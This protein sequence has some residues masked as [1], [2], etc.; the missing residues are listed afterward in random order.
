MKGGSQHFTH[1][2]RRFFVRGLFFVWCAGSV[3]PAAFPVH[4]ADAALGEI[5]D[6]AVQFIGIPEPVRLRLPAAEAGAALAELATDPAVEFA[7]LVVHYQAAA[8][9][10][11]DPYYADQWYLQKIAAPEAWMRTAGKTA[12]VVAVLDTGVDISHPDLSGNIW[13][14]PREVADGRDND[15]NGYVDDLHGWNFYD[16]NS[17]V[18]PVFEAYTPTGIHHGTLIAGEIGAVGGN[19][20]G[21]AGVNWRVSILPLRVL[22]SSGVGDLIN[23]VDGINYAIRA[24]ANVITLSF[25][26][27]NR[28]PILDDAIRRAHDA[29][30]LVVAAAGNDSSKNGGQDLD[31]S[32]VYPACSDGPNGENWVI[33]VAATDQDDRKATFS[34]F[35]RSCVDL[36]APGVGMVSTKVFSANHEGYSEYYGGRYNGTS[37]A[38]PLV[39]G[40]AALVKSANPAL[41]MNQIRELLFAS[42]DGIDA[43]NP[44]YAGKL[45]RG[46]LNVMRALAITPAGTGTSLPISAGGLPVMNMPVGTSGIV[47][48]QG[49]GLPP[50]VTLRTYDGTVHASF[51]AYA[52]TFRGGVKAAVG[53]VDGDG[54]LEIVTVPG[55]GGGPQVRVFTLSG[56]LKHQWN[57]YA[58]TFTGGLNL[59]VGDVDG[60]GVADIVVAPASRLQPLVRVFSG[61]GKQT[62]EFLAY[63]K[64]RTGGVSLAAADTDADGIAEIVTVPASN[65]APHVRIYDAKGNREGEFMSGDGKTVSGY[66]LAA[67]DVNGDGKADVATVDVKAGDM[68]RFSSADGVLVGEVE[69]DGFGP[70]FNFALADRSF[71]GR[72]DLFLGILP[73]TSRVIRTYDVLGKS[74]G[75]ILL[76][77]G[78]SLGAI[79][80]V[81]VFGLPL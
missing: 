10:A 60:D 77:T 32:P 9:G 13:T 27:S 54:N 69:L 37:L 72:A 81:P 39:A 58:S 76:G 5:A 78:E 4:A 6:V 79:Q 47:T 56:K 80:V 8:L 55:T 2:L 25:T 46:R 44:A 28:S 68:I 22:S 63:D 23:V 11:N 3:L 53:D 33:G 26:G 67:G 15:G 71:D 40:A 74:L 62:S 17:N 20:M 36:S 14:N 7:E 73:K 45:G 50:E 16:N 61:T 43:A 24:G 12:V 52:A 1:Q 42:A 66:V 51:L 48:A 70:G 19:G 41:T 31:A 64:V 59:A 35:G 30:I 38:A 75:E 21:V 57:A 18:S 65:G 49:A 29:G 34:D